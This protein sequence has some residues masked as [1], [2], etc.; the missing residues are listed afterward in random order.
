MNN[1]ETGDPQKQRT[2]IHRD[3]EA[4]LGYM[5]EDRN[6][7]IVSEEPSVLVTSKH[8]TYK[9]FQ[10][11]KETLRDSDFSLKGSPNF[12]NLEKRRLE[13]LNNKFKTKK[14]ERR[15]S[16]RIEITPQFIKLKAFARNRSSSNHAITID[17]ESNKNLQGRRRS[18]F[19]TPHKHLNSTKVSNSVTN[20]NTSGHFQFKLKKGLSEDQLIKTLRIS[21]AN[22]KTPMDTLHTLNSSDSIESKSILQNL[23]FNNLPNC[24]AKPKYRLDVLRHVT[25]SKNIQKKE[26]FVENIFFKL[27]C[28]LFYEGSLKFG[29]LHGEGTLFL[30]DSLG[31][32]ENSQTK[33][34]FKLY[35]GQ[36]SENR[37]HGKGLLRFADGSR[38]E[39]RFKNGL[40]H[41]PGKLYIQGPEVCIIEG[42]WLE[43]L[44]FD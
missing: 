41:G 43:G 30:E 28:G 23:S 33:K 3:V 40:A 14:E 16:E 44:F 13:R 6:L 36:F 37:V 4:Q 17:T 20:D 19:A 15:M 21:E 24:P 34:Q 7:T 10:D 5:Y 2:R 9:N 29:R 25:L 42:T 38:F 26:Y 27:S 8:F 12:E 11:T 31:H 35:Q 1:M 22:L 39:G 18:F 32:L